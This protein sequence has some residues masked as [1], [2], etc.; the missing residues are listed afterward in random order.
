MA[1]LA[2][3]NRRARQGRKDETGHGWMKEKKRVTSIVKV[4]CWKARDQGLTRNN[5]LSEKH[6][7]TDTYMGFLLVGKRNR[8]RH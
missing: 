7:F 5:I 2:W 8:P 1:E 3:E 4:K 6:S